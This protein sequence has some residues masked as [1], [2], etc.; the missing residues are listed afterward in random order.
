MIE[1]QNRRVFQ[2]CRVNTHNNMSQRK[3]TFWRQIS[4]KSHFQREVIPDKLLNPFLFLNP[5]SVSSS[6]R[7]MRMKSSNTEAVRNVC[8]R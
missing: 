4:V 7:T 2:N 3:V 1:A 8:S 6:D 5:K